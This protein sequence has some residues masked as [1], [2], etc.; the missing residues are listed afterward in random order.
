MSVFTLT[1]STETVFTAIVSLTVHIGIARN[2]SLLLVVVL[3]VLLLIAK[4]VV[5]EAKLRL[6]HRT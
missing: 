2:V 6:C 1:D 3:L 4:H 5:E